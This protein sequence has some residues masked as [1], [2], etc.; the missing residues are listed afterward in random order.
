MRSRA[1]KRMT[2]ERR[3][4]LT[5][6]DTASDPLPDGPTWQVIGVARDTRGG[7][8]DGSNSQQVYLPMPMDRVTDYPLLLRT[9]VDPTL[10]VDRLAP[11]VAQADPTLTVTTATLQ[12][13]LRR[14]DAFLAASFSAAIAASIGLCGLLLASMGI[15]STVSLDVVLRTRE[16]GIRMAIGAWRT[17]REGGHAVH[18]RSAR[19]PAFPSARGIAFLK[20]EYRLGHRHPAVHTRGVR[21]EG[22]AVRSAVNPH[23]LAGE[24]QALGR[25]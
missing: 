12:T 15:Y 5:S 2:V 14:T 10:V 7:T 24:P 16:L 18:D 4:R 21:A 17:S 13:M 11:I 9:S 6:P 8:L 1:R 23:Q 19:V 20:R 22:P 3:S 25:K